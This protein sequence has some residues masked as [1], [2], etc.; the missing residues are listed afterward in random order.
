MSVVGSRA[1][2]F[3]SFCAFALL[4]IGIGLLSGCESQ[5]A[6][7]LVEVTDLTPREIEPGDHL[8]VHGVGFPQGRTGRV[9]MRGTILR[10]G[11]APIRG[12]TVEASGTVVVPDRLE[13]TVR[14]ALAE[15]FCGAGDHAVHATFRGD[16][17]VSFASNNPGAPPLVGMLRGATLDVQPAW[18]HKASIEAQIVEGGRLLAFMGVTPGAPTARGLPVEQVQPS[19]IAHRAGIQVGDVIGAVDGVH[20]LSLGDVVPA[21]ARAIELT[22]RHGDSAF[23]ET[24]TI[25]LVEYA[26]QRVPTEYVPALVIV[27]LALSVLALLVLRGPSSLTSLEN[28]VASR[29]RR[30]TLRATF[31]VLFGSGRHAAL[32]AILSAVVAAVALTPWMI[33]RELDGALLLAVAASMLVW[34]RVAIARGPAASARMLSCVLAAVLVMAAAIA[35]T[36]LQV[37]AIELAEIVRV[38]GP[39]PWDYS[40]ARHPARAILAVVYGAAIVAILRTRAMPGVH[41]LTAPCTSVVPPP[42]PGHAALLERAGVLLAAAL[43]VITFF[44]GWQLSGHTSRAMSLVASGLFVA[45]TWIVAGVLVGV[46]RVLPSHGPRDVVS[47]VVKRLLPWLAVATILA[48]AS[49]RLVPSIAIETAF[50]ATLVA[51]SSLLVLRVATRVHATV[52]RPERHA[53]PLL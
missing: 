34:S 8:E 16:V 35:L 44:G 41:E 48:I 49:R 15:G 36:T 42:P 14:D 37:G 18:A 9:V 31:G 19:S 7:P 26:G 50:A 53:S 47:L 40:A 4:L 5:V 52:T 32:S 28:R 23:E 43:A 51:L 1:F 20:V 11:Q 30:T 25:S 10:A 22:I 27:G 46:S 21:S 24:K 3:V 38:Q 29:V 13:L 39:A 33:G 17:E 45:K 12:A 2:P 6:P